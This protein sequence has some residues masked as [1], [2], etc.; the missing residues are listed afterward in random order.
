MKTIKII[1]TSFLLIFFNCSQSNQIITTS[2]L[3]YETIKEGSGNEAKAGDE[4]L[5]NESMRYSDGTLL[6]STNQIG[7]PVKFL[8]GGNQAIEG[9]DEGVRGMKTGEIRKLIVPPSLSKRKDYPP[10]LSPD[11]TLYY[12]VELVEILKK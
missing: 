9:I 8:I 2:G 10:N 3:T 4:V 11:S 5:I 7:H 12:E 6:F 1:L